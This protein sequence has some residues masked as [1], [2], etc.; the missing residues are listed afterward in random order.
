MSIRSFQN[1]PSNHLVAIFSESGKFLGILRFTY[2]NWWTAL[3]CLWAKF[4]HDGLISQRLCQQFGP[5]VSQVKNLPF[6]ITHQKLFIL[7]FRQ[8]L[9]GPYNGIHFRL[10]EMRIMYD[11]CTTPSCDHDPDYFLDKLGKI[12]A[13]KF[14]LVHVLTKR[15]FD[16]AV[17]RGTYRSICK[18]NFNIGFT[19][20]RDEIVSVLHQN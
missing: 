2:W 19:S 10:K 6:C 15:V 20:F 5:K 17:G 12:D 18:P 1:D 8:V 9:I 4:E 3:Q 11:L 14:C 13:S 16:G 7:Y